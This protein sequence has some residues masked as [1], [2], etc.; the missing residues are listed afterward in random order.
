LEGDKEKERRMVA[1][2]DA[3]IDPWAVVIVPLDASLAHVAV[4]AP[5]DGYD[6]TLEAELVYLES[7]K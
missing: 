5:R 1:G 4:V 2:A 6:L 7:V 3:R